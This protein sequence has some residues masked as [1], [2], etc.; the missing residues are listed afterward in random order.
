MRTPLEILKTYWNYNEFRPPQEEIINTVIKGENCVVLLPTGNGKSLCYQVPGL[1]M[2][3]VCIVI[4]PL[5][6][7]IKDQVESLTEKNI[8]SIALTSKLSQ[9][10]V[11]VAFDNLQFG[12]YKF[13]YL[14]PEKLQSPFIQDKIRQLNV[15]F[16]AIDEA[17]C[18]SE[19]GH[20][21]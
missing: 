4:S 12:G 3:G 8:K 13:L 19:W 9:E 21:F 14:S 5:I 18:I 16:I 20:D 6:A 15:S 1:A 7:L 11:I 10:E 2:E 17:H